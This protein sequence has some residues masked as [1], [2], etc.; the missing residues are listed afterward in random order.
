MLEGP[1]S[2]SVLQGPP[3]IPPPPLSE[4]ER[5]QNETKW[6]STLTLILTWELLKTEHTSNL[7]LLPQNS[8]SLVGPQSLFAWWKLQGCSFIN[9]R[10]LQQSVFSKN[11]CSSLREPQ[12]YQQPSLEAK[13]YPWIP[14]KS[15]SVLTRSW[16]GTHTCQSAES[17]DQ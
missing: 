10:S 5:E 7:Y 1:P 4:W 16:C 9:H 14:P 6:S 17:R 2:S 15:L 8:Q 3:E 13:T 12:I 11:D